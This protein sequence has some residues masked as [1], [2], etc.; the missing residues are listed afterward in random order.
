LSFWLLVL[1]TA[2]ERPIS[3]PSKLKCRRM[4]LALPHSKDVVIR[5]S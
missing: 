5:S 4:S 2:R 1:L 3:A